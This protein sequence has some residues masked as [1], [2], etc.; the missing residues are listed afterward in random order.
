MHKHRYYHSEQDLKYN[1]TSNGWT[2][3]LG[4][5]G[6]NSI[7]ATIRGVEKLPIFCAL[8]SLNN[9]EKT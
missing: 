2:L 4:S 9:I 8:K 1:D 3:V 5:A 6:K 7:N